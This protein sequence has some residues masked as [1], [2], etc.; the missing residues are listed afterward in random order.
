VSYGQKN[1]RTHAFINTL[2]DSHSLTHTRSRSLSHSLPRTH[3]H[4]HSHTYT[5][6]LAPTH[7]LTHTRS[8]SLLHSLPRTH[9][10]THTRSRIHTHTHTLTLTHAPTH[11][12]IRGDCQRF[13]GMLLRGERTPEGRLVKGVAWVGVS[14][15]AAV[16][17]YLPM[18][19]PCEGRGA[20][21]CFMFFVSRFK[22]SLLAYATRDSPLHL[23]FSPFLLTRC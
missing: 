14:T 17:R 21:R 5:L 23:L 11:T 20:G 12:R 19:S 10:H 7:T 9:S 15:L 2:I 4:T 8:R 18:L 16:N 1:A 3:S 22:Q 6:T 13:F